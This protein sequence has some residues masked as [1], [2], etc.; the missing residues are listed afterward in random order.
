MA[1]TINASTSSGLIQTADTSGSLQLQ[2]SGTT[3]LTLDTSQNA[4]IAGTL[5]VTG[6]I[7]NSNFTSLGTITPTAANSISLG[8]LTLTSYKQLYIVVNNINISAAGAIYVSSSNVQSGGGIYTNNQSSSGTAWLDLTSGAIG[9]GFTTN[10]VAAIASV[11]NMPQV[12]GLTNVTTSSTTIYFRN[13]ST[14]TFV[15]QGTIYIYGVK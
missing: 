1:V 7:T 3:A 4:T 14:T 6:G 15:A 8:S 9:G 2:T 12:G 13:A 11:G 5:T 10:T